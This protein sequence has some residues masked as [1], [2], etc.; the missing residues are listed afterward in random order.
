MRG[1]RSFW[2]A[3]ETMRELWEQE[4]AFRVLSGPGHDLQRAPM[5]MPTASYSVVPSRVP[6]SQNSAGFVLLIR[7]E[8]YSHWPMDWRVGRWA[9]IVWPPPAP[10]S[11][12][13]RGSTDRVFRV[14]ISERDLPKEVRSQ[15]PK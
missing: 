12:P 7:S 8:P 4:N 10:V 3:F 6:Y 2:S 14:W 15:L 13:W 9:L 1:S 5:A 11:W